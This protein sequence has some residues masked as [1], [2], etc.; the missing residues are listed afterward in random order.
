MSRDQRLPLRATADERA[1]IIRAASASGL[2]V[3]EFAMT[4]LVEDSRRVLADRTEFVLTP[5]Q[6]AE[7]EAINSQPARDLPRL[8]ASL[9]K[10]APWDAGGNT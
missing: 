10:A 1:L 2:K 4:H 6:A 3:S 7:W 9:A 8:R 5:E